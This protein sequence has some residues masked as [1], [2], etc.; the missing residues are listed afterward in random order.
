MSSMENAFLMLG[1]IKTLILSGNKLTSC[2]G[3]DRLY[4]L[5][6]L[7]L[8]RN[9]IRY[10]PDVSGIANLPELMRFEMKG[11]PLEQDGEKFTC[12][13]KKIFMLL[14]LL[15]LISNGHK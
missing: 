6:R 13:H 10:L 9:Q 8:D 1:N 11:N 4:S 14:L 12:F 7:A 5:E 3:L 2:N 15:N